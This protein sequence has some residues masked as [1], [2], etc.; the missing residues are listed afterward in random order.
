M[1]N[2]GHQQQFNP[3]IVVIKNIPTAL[4]VDQ[5]AAHTRGIGLPLPIKLN[6]NYENR[7]FTGI[8]FAD[9]ETCGEA[10]TFMDAVNDMTLQGRKLRA[11]YK[12]ILPAIE[13]DRIKHEKWEREEQEKLKRQEQQRREQQERWERQE[14]HESRSTTLS[15]DL[16]FYSCCHTLTFSRYGHEQSCDP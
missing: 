8:A 1:N 14:Q 5:L 10:T 15:E 3:R 6:Y 4:T 9:F 16:Y 7:S 11:E 12:T 2:L 13:L